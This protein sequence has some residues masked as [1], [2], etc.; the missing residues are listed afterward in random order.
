MITLCYNSWFSVVFSTYL[1]LFKYSL[2]TN[3]LRHNDLKLLLLEG[4][5]TTTT[6]QISFI[7]KKIKNVNTLFLHR[8][9]DDSHDSFDD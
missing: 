8:L 3:D 4:C 6:L 9:T 2:V 1:D 7:I 5:S